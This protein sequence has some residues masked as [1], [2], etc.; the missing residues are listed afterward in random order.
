[1]KKPPIIGYIVCANMDPMHAAPDKPGDPATLWLGHQATLFPSRQIAKAYIR[2][3]LAY[4][5][6]SKYFWPWV[7]NATIM[8]V[9]RAV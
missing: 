6:R 1:M 3:T 5:A 7:E 4:A 8:A 9:R 2:R